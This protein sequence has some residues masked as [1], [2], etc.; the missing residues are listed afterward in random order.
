MS[1]HWAALESASLYVPYIPDPKEN[2]RGMRPYRTEAALASGSIRSHHMGSFYFQ[3]M[4]SYLCDFLESYTTDLSALFRRAPAPTRG[5]ET[6]PDNIGGSL[7]L[8]RDVSGPGDC[9]HDADHPAHRGE[10]LHQIYN[11]LEIDLELVNAR[12]TAA[13][14]YWSRRNMIKL[15]EVDDLPVIIEVR[16]EPGGG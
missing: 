14:W 15:L 13:N 4:T 10:Y 11:L 3:A 1:S 6:F 5:S 9:H 8:L 2:L 12:V 16:R 7:F